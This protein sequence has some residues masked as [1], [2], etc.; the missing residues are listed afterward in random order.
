MSFAEKLAE[1]AWRFNLNLYKGTTL[2]AKGSWTGLPWSLYGSVM[3]DDSSN[4]SSY[5][6]NL[7]GNGL[8]VQKEI[9]PDTAMKVIALVVGGQLPS[10][11]G[12][13]A[14]D[15][16][17]SPP[18]PPA[19]RRGTKKRGASSKKARKRRRSSPGI[20]KDLSTRPKGKKAF[21]E[22]ASEKSPTTHQ[23][24]Q[25]VAVYWLRKTAGVDGITVDHVN[26]CYQAAGWPRPK[27][28]EN[29]LA[30][31]AM[32]KGWLDTSDMSAIDITASGEDAVDHDLPKKKD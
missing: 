2:L 29:A 23:E 4:A 22:F 13:P 5:S 24:K 3:T 19:R 16:E 11:E 15:V 21:A 31:T 10:G 6:I 28:L 8:S 18:K 25:V 7:T 27:D 12:H 14:L 32:R 9:D 30:V 17:Q 1:T 20:V 26:T